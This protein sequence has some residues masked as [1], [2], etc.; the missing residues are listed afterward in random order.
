MDKPHPAEVRST[1]AR[2]SEL[3]GDILNQLDPKLRKLYS[4]LPPEQSSAIAKL[5]TQALTLGIHPN[6][7]VKYAFLFNL[8][9]RQLQGEAVSIEHTRRSKAE[10][11]GQIHGVEEGYIN[12][13]EAIRRYRGGRRPSQMMDASLASL[14]KKFRSVEQV[15]RKYRSELPLHQQARLSDER[16]AEVPKLLLKMQLA[17]TVDQPDFLVENKPGRPRSAAARIFVLWRLGMVRYRGN[18]DDMHRLATVWRL[19][20]AQDVETFRIMVDQACKGLKTKRGE[21]ETPWDSVLSSKS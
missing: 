7:L 9:M 21:L 1:K 5:V 4:Q 8:G 15:I 20:N 18:W 6:M 2:P 19:T 3:P 17:V 14:V 11:V 13:E 10:L 16:L 12:E